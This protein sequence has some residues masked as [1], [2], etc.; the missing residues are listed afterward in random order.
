MSDVDRLENLYAFECEGG[1]LKNCV[2]WQALKTRIADAER[3][4]AEEWSQ[5]MMVY[6][7]FKR[8]IP[9]PWQFGYRTSVGGG[10][11]RMGLWNGDRTHGPIVDLDEIETRA[12]E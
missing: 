3:G 10:L 5:S 11:V 1:P 9:G 6:W 12:H 7:R 4:S 2:E 8:N